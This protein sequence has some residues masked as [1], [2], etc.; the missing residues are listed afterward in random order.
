MTGASIKPNDHTNEEC[1]NNSTNTTTTNNNNFNDKEAELFVDTVIE[2][3]PKLLSIIDK[4]IRRC[5]PSFLQPIFGK[6]QLPTSFEIEFSK[7]ELEYTKRIQIGI[8]KLPSFMNYAVKVRGWLSLS[9][10]YDA[11]IFKWCKY[12]DD[13]SS[14]LGHNFNLRSQKETELTNVGLLS[15]LLFTG[16]FEI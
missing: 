8:E 13:D 3:L 9:N 15:A 7:E 6:F 1:E 16:K 4:Y 11:Y 2:R 14:L 5:L 10:L 12:L